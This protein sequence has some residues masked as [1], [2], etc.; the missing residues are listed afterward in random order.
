MDITFGSDPE[1]FVSN[2][3]EIVPAFGFLPSNKQAS[4]NKKMD[5]AA[6]YD[7]DSLYPYWDGFQAEFRSGVHSCR[8]ELTSQVW[9]GLRAIHSKAPEGSVID[10]RSVVEIPRNILKNVAEEHA[11]LGCDPSLNVYGPEP[12]HISDARRLKYRFAGHH[13]HF[14][15]DRDSRFNNATKLHNTPKL[16]VNAVQN[17]DATLGLVGVSLFENLDDPVRRKYYGRAGEFRLPQHGIEYRTL[18]SSV[19]IHPAIH[20]LLWDIGGRVFRLCIEQEWPDN[21]YSNYD[22]PV[23]FPNETLDMSVVRNAINRYEADVA[24]DLLVSCRPFI[25]HIF[26]MAYG[27]SNK[28]K[29]FAWK[30]ILQPVENTVSMDVMT[31]WRMDVPYHDFKLD[32]FSRLGDVIAPGDDY[33]VDDRYSDYDDYDD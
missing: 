23:Q 8:D 24:R 13:F 2:G 33:F 27:Y 15:F 26:Q 31:N 11:A 29:E 17:L 6:S 22:F 9:S 19:L 21:C 20:H 12:I 4:I 28:L 5:G 7:A 32:R 16:V 3:G 14:G 25:D 30:T 18:S 1:V 10:V